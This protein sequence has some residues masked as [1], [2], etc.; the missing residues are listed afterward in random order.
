MAALPMLTTTVPLPTNHNPKK[1]Q[2]IPI[3]GSATSG[4]SAIYVSA[5][6]PTYARDR[7]F[8]QTG[9]ELFNLGLDNF[10]KSPA[11]GRRPW[12]EKVNDWAKEVVW[13]TYE[14]VDGH[15]HR[16]GSGL[17]QL[18]QELFPD[19]KPTEWKVGIWSPNRPE[20]QH[21]NLAVSAYSLSIVSLYETFGPESVKFIANHAEMRIIFAASGHI[22]TLL[23]MKAKGDLPTVVAVVSL[24]EWASIDARNARP[25]ARSAETFKVWG[26]SVGVKVV[27]LVEL[28]AVGAANLVPHRP[29]TPDSILSICYTSGTTGNPKGAIIFHSNVAAV[30]NGSKHGHRLDHDDV[31]ISYLPLA[32]IYGYFTEMIV[33]SAGAR[34]AYHCGDTLRLLEDFQVLKP[35]FLISVP[36]VLNRVYQAIKAQTLDAAGVKGA[37]ARKAF[38][39]KLHNLNATGQVTHAIWDRILFNKVKAVLGGNVRFISSGSAPIN[40]DVLAFLRVA[41]SCDVIEGFGQ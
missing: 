33:F 7:S 3:P 1:P 13:E 31:M 16:I 41:F 2:S 12:D 17:V 5:A 21:V 8:P 38:A 37:L 34:I 14:E 4:S 9:Y 35:T 32:H 36:R 22:P 30:A 15:R 6:F 24:D 23:K 29:P 10:A 20:W 18:Q 40:P 26:D 39:D 27:D 19:E 28:E 11:L 25:G